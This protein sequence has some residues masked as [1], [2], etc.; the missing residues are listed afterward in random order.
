MGSSPKY[1][2]SPGDYNKY[3]TYTW[4][5]F[6]KANGKKYKFTRPEATEVIK[7][8]SK[9]CHDLLLDNADGIRFNFGTLMVAGMQ[10]DFVDKSRSTKDKPILFRNLKTD[11][12]VYTIKYIFGRERG[13]VYTGVLWKFRSTVPLRQRMKQIIDQGNHRHWY[14]FNTLGDVPNIGIPVEYLKHDK[15]RSNK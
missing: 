1:I 14:V 6:I 4:D 2:K 10:G 12:V 7:R 3:T 9:R 15:K 13:R 8:F 11:R 5:E